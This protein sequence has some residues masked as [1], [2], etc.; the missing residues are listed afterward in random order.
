MCDEDKDVVYLS[1]IGDKYHYLSWMMHPALK[2]Y[3][4]IDFKSLKS[5]V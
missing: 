4:L 2:T 3:L 5:A 1:I